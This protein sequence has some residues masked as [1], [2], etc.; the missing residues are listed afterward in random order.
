MRSDIDQLQ[1][2]HIVKDAPCRGGLYDLPEE[3]FQ[4]LRRVAVLEDVSLRS[5]GLRQGDLDGQRSA[6][7]VVHISTLRD[8]NVIPMPMCEL[9][10]SGTHLR[11]VV[12]MS[13]EKHDGVG[14]PGAACE[15]SLEC[16]KQVGR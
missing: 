3:H 14:D 8:R 9:L 12:R 5:G 13:V 2:K 11:I 6:K 7:R 4:L 16:L 1:V 10:H 15:S